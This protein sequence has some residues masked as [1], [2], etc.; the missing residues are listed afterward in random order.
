MSIVSE[1]IYL[2]MRA[3]LLE[4]VDVSFQKP[5]SDFQLLK[6]NCIVK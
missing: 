3:V 2:V 5:A 6:Q 1:N 4:T